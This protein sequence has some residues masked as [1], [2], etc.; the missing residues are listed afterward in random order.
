VFAQ[1]HPSNT[2]KMMLMISRTDPESPRVKKMVQDDYDEF[3]MPDDYE[4]GHFGAKFGV[5][6]I[7]VRKGGVTSRL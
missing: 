3:K 7:Y 5:A 1:F 2:L 4:T 6:G